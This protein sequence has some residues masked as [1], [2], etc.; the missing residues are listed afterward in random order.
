MRSPKFL[1]LA[2]M[3]VT[4]TSLAAGVLDLW[5]VAD[6]GT[7]GWEPRI[8]TAA[9]R[10]YGAMAWHAAFPGDAPADGPQAARATTAPGRSAAT[11]R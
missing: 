5:Q 9:L 4:L 3:L 7:I 6:D 10:K 11:A 2:L 1:L 8:R